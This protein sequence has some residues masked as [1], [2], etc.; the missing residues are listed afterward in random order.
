MEKQIIEGN[1]LIAEFM[2]AST[3]M[4]DLQASTIGKTRV[5]TGR[6]YF[7]NRNPDNMHL[8][9]IEDLK[10]HSS[11]DWLMPVVQ[12]IESL[13]FTVCIFSGCCDIESKT[14]RPTFEKIERGGGQPKILST[15][16]SCI[17]FIQWYNTQTQK[18]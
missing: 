9:L 8:C 10:Y 2:G 1:K 4:M 18:Q 13:G 7:T 14:D 12:K 15:W 16:Q 17:D 3:E 5:P 11:F 6:I